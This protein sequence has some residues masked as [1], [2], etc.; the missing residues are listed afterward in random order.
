MR[1]TLACLALL[2]ARGA[3]VG[4]GSE[5]RAML[6]SVARMVDST[7]A[8]VDD[9]F[10]D[11]LLQCMGTST[12]LVAA[13]DSAWAGFVAYW[14]ANGTASDGWGACTA[15]TGC[16]EY[17]ELNLTALDVDGVQIFE[18]C[19][20]V[21]NLAFYKAA[22][23]VC[24]RDA[25]S[26]AVPADAREALV[27]GLAH[28][29][30]GSYFWH[31]SRSWL[32]NVA[33]NRLIDVIAFVAWQAAAEPLADAANTTAARTTL[34]DLSAEG[35]R[36]ASAV[37]SARALTETLLSAPLDTWQ[38]SIT[39]LDMPVYFISFAALAAEVLTLALPDDPALVGDIIDVAASAI[40]MSA[41][42]L[43][44]IDASLLPALRGAAAGARL[45]RLERLALGSKFAGVMVKMVYAFLWQGGVIEWAHI[46]GPA[47][48]RVGATLMPAAN[49]LANLLTGFQHS[50]R[51]VQECADSV[52]PAAARCR[53]EEQAPHS[54]WHEMSANGLLDLVFLADDMRSLTRGALAR[55]ARAAAGADPSGLAL[56]SVATI[57]GWAA[58]MRALI[59]L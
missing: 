1:A 23:G 20:S 33:D 3:A 38:Q 46:Y 49:R 19:N 8:G 59:G 26:W 29:A 57:R 54:K 47:A 44:F 22:L 56:F 34:L 39:D 9:G 12:D 50:D 48:N 51:A 30:W 32:G 53:L 36:S 13:H 55:G 5:T 7:L 35:N 10:F 28:M 16:H 45:T 18:P 17:R 58:T 52:Y 2:A 37:D 25:A 40:G 41:D 11:E 4:N 14:D 42:D 6:D 43:R 27:A 24:A 15:A 31:G 21:S